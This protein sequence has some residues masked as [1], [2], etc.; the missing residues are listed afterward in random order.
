MNSMEESI[1]QLAAV[2]AELADAVRTESDYL[3]SH[4]HMRT[5][6]RNGFLIVP[7]NAHSAHEEIAKAREQFAKLEAKRNRLV[8][9]RNDILRQYADLKMGGANGE[10]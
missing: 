5:E 8:E 4:R 6:T 10:R 2:N 3:A 9:R 7:L 1:A